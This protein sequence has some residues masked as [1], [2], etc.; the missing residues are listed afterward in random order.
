MIADFIATYH[1]Y[2]RSGSGRR[3]ALHMAWLLARAGRRTR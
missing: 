1:L 3:Q 2:R